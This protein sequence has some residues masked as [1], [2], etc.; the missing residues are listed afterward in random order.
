M[1]LLTRACG[2]HAVEDFPLVASILVTR[3][4]G[5]A[6][7]TVVIQA[8]GGRP[9]RYAHPCTLHAAAQ[10][11]PIYALRLACGAQRALLRVAVGA[12]NIH[13]VRDRCRQTSDSIIA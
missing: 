2:L 10:L 3:I 4:P 8:V 11:Q 13:D 7:S 1:K 6:P 5:S 9:P 12:M